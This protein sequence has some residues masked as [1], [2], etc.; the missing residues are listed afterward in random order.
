MMEKKCVFIKSFENAQSQMK[1][2]NRKGIDH[3]DEVPVTSGQ[4]H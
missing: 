3:Q 2:E 1:C 4:S